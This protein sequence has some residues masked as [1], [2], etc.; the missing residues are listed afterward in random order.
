MPL[1]AAQVAAAREAVRSSYLPVGYARLEAMLGARPYF[2]GGWLTV[3]DLAAFVEL[4]QLLEGKFEAL[5]LTAQ[6]LDDCPNL[7]AHCLRV[8]RNR[9]VRAWYRRSRQA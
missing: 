2:C 9:R 3:A 8:G 5:G 1:D 4:S 7:R 6:I